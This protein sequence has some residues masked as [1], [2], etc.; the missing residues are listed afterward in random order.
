ML[1]TCDYVDRMSNVQIRHVP[2]ELHRRL[3]A[4]AALEGTTVSDL[5]LAE[6]VRFLERPP[7]AE[8]VARIVGRD[9][10]CPKESSADAVR[11]GRDAG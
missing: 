5:L 10:V 7:K 9:A 1:S 6:L 8:V 11:A 4:R 3:R 2:E